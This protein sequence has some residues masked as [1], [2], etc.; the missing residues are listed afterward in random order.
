MFYMFD[1]FLLILEGYF[2][3]YGKVRE[4]MEYFLFLRILFEI[5]MNLVEFLLD[6]VIG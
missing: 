2:V 6:L 3:Y 5:V 4:V 1:K